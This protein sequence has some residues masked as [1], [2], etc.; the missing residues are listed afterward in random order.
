MNLKIPMIPGKLP[1]MDDWQSKFRKDS[2]LPEISWSTAR[3]VAVKNDPYFTI[4]CAEGVI[5]SMGALVT[6]HR[7]ISHARPAIQ[8][9]LAHLEIQE[10]VCYCLGHLE[11]V[12][13]N[14]QLAFLLLLANELRSAPTAM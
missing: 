1:A 6:S 14:F 5:K 4:R 7:W 11:D 2:T 3:A 10:I 12:N 8:K 9:Q 13:V